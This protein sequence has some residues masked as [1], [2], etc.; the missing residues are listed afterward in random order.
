[1]AVLKIAWRSLRRH[2]RRSIITG[3][4]VALGLAL[5]LIFIGLNDDGHARMIDIGIHMGAG[6]VVVQG[7][8]YQQDQTLD[9]I[10]SDPEAVMAAARRVPEVRHVAARVRAGG[11]LSS[12]VESTAVAVN[13]VDPTVEPQVSTIAQERALVAGSYLRPA[14]ELEFE[15][16]PADIYVGKDLARR[17]QLELGDRVVLTVSPRG[18]G[19]P[20]SAAFLVRGIFRTGMDELDG[21]YVEIPIE[22]AQSLLALGGGVTQVALLI[23][24]VKNAGRVAAE[25]R[26]EL[27]ERAD[28]EVLPWQQALREL[29]EYVL[30]DDAGMYVLMAVVFLII[31][32]GIFN[33]V[34]MS[35]LERTH[36]FGVM[37]AIGTSGRRI[38]AIVVVEALLLGVFATAV[39]LGI[40]LGVHSWIAST[41]IDVTALYGEGFEFA[42]IVFEGRIYSLLTTA[43]VV[44]WCLI[45]IGLVVASALYPA[46]RTTRLEPVEAM[47][48]V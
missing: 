33:T 2:R 9:H 47:R 17:L 26:R 4:A 13:G 19:R 12:G 28:L 14:T 31:G 25:M 23:D 37:M 29:Y 8:G 15:N 36:E 42:G 22:Q 16:Q 43:T 3:A 45:V 32:I 18:G 40:G 34:L 35:V 24:D 46:W 11:L 10:V 20:S 21:F 39:G 30:I 7:N 44:R 48:H 38:F 27:G 6:H 1:V 41:G 5:M